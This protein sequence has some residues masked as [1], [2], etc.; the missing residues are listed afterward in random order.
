MH[1]RKGGINPF[2]LN[3]EPDECK[4]GFTPTSP[5]PGKDPLVSAEY[6]AG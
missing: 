3:P 6:E 1:T 5:I 4:V 2:I